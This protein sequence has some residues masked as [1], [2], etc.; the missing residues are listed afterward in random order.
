MPSNF[1]RV[2]FVMSDPPA[3]ECLCATCDKNPAEHKRIMLQRLRD[4]VVNVFNKRSHDIFPMRLCRD[5]AIIPARKCGCL[6]SPS[7]FL[8]RLIKRAVIPLSTQHLLH[9]NKLSAV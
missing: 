9:A 6:S 2:T 4:D 7:V 1:E 8:Q 3:C 5:H